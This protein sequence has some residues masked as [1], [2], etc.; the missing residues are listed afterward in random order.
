MSPARA[1]RMSQP[2]RGQTA[3]GRRAQASTEPTRVVESP[4]EGNGLHQRRATWVELK[5]VPT[6]YMFGASI[7]SSLKGLEFIFQELVPFLSAFIRLAMNAMKRALYR[8]KGAPKHNQGMYDVGMISHTSG[9]WSFFQKVLL[10][11]HPKNDTLVS[12]WKGD[13]QEKM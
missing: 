3:L 6:D 10:S 4:T 11:P 2:L 13:L 7:G 12:S 5:E 9:I 8:A 1:H